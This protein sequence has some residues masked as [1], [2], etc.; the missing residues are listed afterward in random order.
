M[1]KS[2][3]EIIKLSNEQ[4]RDFYDIILEDDVKERNVTKEES[5]EK[6]T[7]MYNIMKE[8][9]LR[10]NKE[11]KSASKLSGGDGYLMETAICQGN[12]L[13]GDFISKV[14]MRALKMGESNACMKRIVAA[15]TAGSCGVIPA[16]FISYQEKNNIS[17]Q[18]MIKGL[19]VSAG[20]GQ[21]IAL[22]ASISGAQGG[23]QAEIGSASAMAAG[24]LS[25]LRG[26]DSSTIADASALALKSLLGLTCD[27]VGGLVEVPCIK[28]NVIGAV[29][30]ITASDMAMAGM[31][32]R[33][34]V[35]E[36][37]DAMRNIGESMPNTLRETSRGGLAITP[38][39][40]NVKL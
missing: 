21:V 35:D 33:I 3:E 4:S 38:T 8:A 12:M 6:M 20:I 9:D 18:M 31:K 39:G 29:N 26:G 5:I 16:V 17:D 30:A 7:Q 19:Y 1:Y 14:M 2:I 37:I 36:V 32:S 13:S 25:Y 40:L 23:C 10:Y 15:P 27:P 24:A 28:R 34:P 11:L 22:R